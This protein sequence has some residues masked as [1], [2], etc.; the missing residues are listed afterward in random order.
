MNTLDKERFHRLNK[1]PQSGLIKSLGK[2]TSPKVRLEEKLY[3]KISHLDELTYENNN[4]S[5]DKPRM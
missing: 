2:I 5:K 3:I 1:W 4:Y